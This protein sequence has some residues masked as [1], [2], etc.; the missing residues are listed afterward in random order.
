MRS[1]TIILPSGCESLNR[2]LW[3]VDLPALTAFGVSRGVIP[4]GGDLG[5]A[6]HSSLLALYGQGAPKPF[7]LVHRPRDGAFNLL[8][9][10]R[11]TPQALND[12]A[13]V[14]ATLVRD[15]S[16]AAKGIDPD[17]LTVSPLPLSWQA[18][19]RLA[20]EARL[21]PMVRTTRND[22]RSS[23]GGREID[24]FIAASLK[25]SDKRLYRE[26][27]YRDWVVNAFVRSGAVA[28]EREDIRFTQMTR[29]RLFTGDRGGHVQRIDKGIEGPLI[30]V[31]G[32]LTILEPAGFTPFLARG[33]GRH[34]SFGFGMVQLAPAP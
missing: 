5:Y 7:R 14:Q 23:E 15:F 6:I 28:V 24:A 20:F 26:D 22:P 32:L 31:E 13:A 33:M 16:R 34:R 17:T 30:C 12:R 27:V 8:A 2:V 29:T 10:T 3:R 4:E 11:L 21:R 18:G 19:R 1:S 9:Y 25:A